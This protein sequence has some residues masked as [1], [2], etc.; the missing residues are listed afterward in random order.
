MRIDETKEGCILEI[1]VRPRSNEFSIVVQGDD[2]VVHCREEP[3][4]G[5]VNRELV[6]E[7]SRLFGK[8]VELVSGFSSR[9]KRLLV[10]GVKKSEIEGFVKPE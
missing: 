10:R 3:V 2:I 1:S 6:K 4:R 9:E 8:K 5:R 7:L